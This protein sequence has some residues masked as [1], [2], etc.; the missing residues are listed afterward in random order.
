MRGE[1]NHVLRRIHQ[2]VE[3][4]QIREQ[5]LDR[6]YNHQQKIKQAFDRKKK[7][8]NLSRVIWCSN[9]MH[10]GRKRENTVNLMPSGSGL[11]RSLKYFQTTLTGCR[12]WKAMKF[13]VAQSMG[14]S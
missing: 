9:G 12:I 10:P 8:K 1:P 13:L 5:V 6:A 4:Q 11:S 14:I 7:R 3:V 2:M